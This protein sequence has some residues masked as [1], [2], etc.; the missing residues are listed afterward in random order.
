[1]HLYMLNYLCVLNYLQLLYLLSDVAHSFLVL[2]VRV[3]ININRSG[4]E[5]KQNL[6]SMMYIWLL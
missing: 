1:M 3:K 6:A 2:Q 5:L 4:T